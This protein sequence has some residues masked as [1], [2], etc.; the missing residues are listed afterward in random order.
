M[1]KPQQVAECLAHANEA[2]QK[3]ENETDARTRQE[4]SEVE[5]RWLHLIRLSNSIRTASKIRDGRA[6][7]ITKHPIVIVALQTIL[8][9]VCVV[10]AFACKERSEQH[11]PSR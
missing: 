6:L 1:E 7:Q 2:H 11:N 5:R 8:L 3:A 9:W 10:V 4:W